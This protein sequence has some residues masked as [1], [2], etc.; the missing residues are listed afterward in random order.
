MEYTRVRFKRSKRNNKS[1]EYYPSFRHFFTK[2][3]RP[4]PAPTTTSLDYNCMELY[5]KLPDRTGADMPAA[6]R[7]PLLLSRQFMYVC[8]VYT[9]K[10]SLCGGAAVTSLPPQRPLVV[11][12]RVGLGWRGEET[13]L[14]VSVALLK[15]VGPV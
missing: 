7:L 14:S 6:A 8:V 4:G 13:Y 12:C 10:H 15:T 11:A 2:T 5:C 3:V 9:C 1:R